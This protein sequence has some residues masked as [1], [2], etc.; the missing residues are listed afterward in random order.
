MKDLEIKDIF[1]KVSEGVARIT[2]VVIN[3][4]ALAIL[5]ALGGRNCSCVEI[6]LG[7]L[8]SLF[9]GL[10]CEVFGAEGRGRAEKAGR[11]QSFRRVTL[12]SVVCGVDS[13]TEIL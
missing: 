4:V 10:L 8:T 6:I 9:C 13:R 1:E 12:L 3:L 11:S 5:V 7:F 2:G